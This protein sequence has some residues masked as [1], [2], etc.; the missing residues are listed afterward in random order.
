MATMDLSMTKSIAFVKEA[1]DTA[2][3]SSASSMRKILAVGASLPKT[4]RPN[5][6]LITSLQDRI[7]ELE[8]H[9][10]S[11]KEESRQLRAL[12]N[13]HRNERRRNQSDDVRRSAEVERILSDQMLN[14]RERIEVLSKSK[15][16]MEQLLKQEKDH[17]KRLE[18]MIKEQDDAKKFLLKK[19]EEE[20]E[21]LRSDILL[22]SEGQLKEVERDTVAKMKLEI[23]KIK[24]ESEIALKKERAKY[25][26]IQKDADALL[27]KE[28]VKSKKMEKERDGFQEAAEKERIKMRKLVKV[29][30]ERER[31]DIANSKASISSIDS[32][33]S[34]TNTPTIVSA[35][36]S[37]MVNG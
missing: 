31:K 6:H 9:I 19:H 7:L 28:R 23:E 13:E 34:S 17:V 37:G 29:L 32:G 24:K 10:R 33:S 2:F 18:R 30:A 5:T 4:F 27:E 26:K 14:L 3:A 22:K 11:G 21:Q 25:N 1:A 36:A 12:L 35:G 8:R 15:G 16:E 20:L